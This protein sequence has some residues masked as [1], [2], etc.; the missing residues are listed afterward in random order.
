MLDYLLSNHDKL[1]YII[2]GH[3]F[4]VEMT[5]I[6]LSGPLLFIAI[7]SLVTGILVSLNILSSWEMEVLSVG[8]FTLLSALL[9]WAPFKRLQG[10]GKV[11]DTSSDMIGKIVLASSPI[12][13]TAGTLR[14]S[15]ID[16]QA[17]L[18]AT[19]KSQLVKKGA[20]LTIIAV[21]G[22]TMIVTQ[23]IDSIL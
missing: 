17:R 2:A 12:S 19:D 6:G 21:D 1:L 22:N 5:L 16:W 18:S 14:Y 20:Q 4:L 9:L 3:C 7:G 23:A 13:T 11:Q 15:G 8:I 10:K